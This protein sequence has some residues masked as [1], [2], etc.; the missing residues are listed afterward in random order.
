M[1]K[2]KMKALF[3]IINA[4]YANEIVN[5]LR[6]SGA[7]GATILNTRGEDTMH[8]SFMG[9]TID[10]EKELVV[11]VVEEDIALKSMKLIKEKMGRESTASSVC[12]TMPIDTMIGINTTL[13]SFLDDNK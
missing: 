7:K 9:I 10:S 11:C 4:G 2:N 12:F 5:L 8:R 3:I 1:E 13:D 6:E